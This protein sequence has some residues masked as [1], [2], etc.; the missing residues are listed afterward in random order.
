MALGPALRNYSISSL[1]LLRGELNADEF[2]MASLVDDMH[3]LRAGRSAGHS[4]RSAAM[5]D[6]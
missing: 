1:Q 6:A 3:W 2:V 4:G 5:P